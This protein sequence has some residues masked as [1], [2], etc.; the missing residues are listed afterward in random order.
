MQEESPAPAE[1]S[2]APVATAPVNDEPKPRAANAVATPTEEVPEPSIATPVQEAPLS[3]AAPVATP[4]EEESSQLPAA[5][6]EEN[7]PAVKEPANEET[8]ESPATKDEPSSPGSEA[9][10]TADDEGEDTAKKSI[11]LPLPTTGPRLVSPNRTARPS[12][13]TASRRPQKDDTPSQTELLQQELEKV[14]DANEKGK[15]YPKQWMTNS[16]CYWG[17]RR[18]KNQAPLPPNLRRLHRNPSNPSL[19][20]SPHPSPWAARV[21]PPS[22]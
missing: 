20:N 7:T 2:P 16:F 3:P 9:T 6:V 12:N 15:S 8:L 5:V 19:R 13:R 21:H 17:D 4:A 10:P 11:G 1:E 22:I 18:Q 14:M